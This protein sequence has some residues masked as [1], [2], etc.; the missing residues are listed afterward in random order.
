MH[1][2]KLNTIVIKYIME[3]LGAK[4]CMMLF[5]LFYSVCTGCLLADTNFNSI[6]MM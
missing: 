1:G 3:S 5:F 2:K 4:L 6:K